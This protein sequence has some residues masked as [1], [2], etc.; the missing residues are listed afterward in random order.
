MEVSE[1]LEGFSLKMNL[2]RADPEVDMCSIC[3]LF[4]GAVYEA[5]G[6]LIGDFSPDSILGSLE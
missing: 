3:Q 5:I 4:K 6:D 2:L 1:G